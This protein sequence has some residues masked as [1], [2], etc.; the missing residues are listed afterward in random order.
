[1][2]WPTSLRDEAMLSCRSA[3][4]VAARS[5]SSARPAL[6]SASAC[7]RS[8]SFLMPSAVWAI[9][10]AMNLLS[11]ARSILLRASI[12]WR[13]ASV[14]FFS[15]SAAAAA[16]ISERTSARVASRLDSTAAFALHPTTPIDRRM[17]ATPPKSIRR[18][19]SLR[20]VYLKELSILAITSG[21]GLPSLLRSS[22]SGMK[23]G[24]GAA[25]AAGRAPVCGA[26][27]PR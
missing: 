10:S 22:D 3:L 6:A 23:S 16:A 8:A 15:A 19:H 5:R 18:S 26:T 27:A 12:S 20:L 7:K 25:A 24:A 4:A 21:E 17:I 14:T 13:S 9:A 11:L 2:D 1:M